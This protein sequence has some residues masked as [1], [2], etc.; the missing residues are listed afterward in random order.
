M[1][2]NTEM[3]RGAVECMTCR[4]HNRA[5]S[6][7]WIDA[8]DPM[9]ADWLADDGDELLNRVHA[10]TR[11]YP[12]CEELWCTDV[13]YLPEDRECGID[14]LAQVGEIFDMYDNEGESWEIVRAWLNTLSIDLDTVTRHDLREA[15]RGTWN[16]FEDY[17]DE[18]FWECYG[19]V[20]D[21]SIRGYI[22]TKRY[23]RDIEGEYLTADVTG[24][25]AVFLA[26]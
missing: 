11:R 24:G 2:S 6:F 14:Y 5:M 15:Y 19:E 4:G 9:L 3:P 18:E 22:D 17:A 23:A 10:D 20:V 16:S 7:A 21:D 12:D 25:V 1:N 8:N 13:E 26:V